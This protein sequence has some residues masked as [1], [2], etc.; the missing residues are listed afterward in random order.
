MIKHQRRARSVLYLVCLG[1]WLAGCTALGPSPG[2][3]AEPAGAVAGAADEAPFWYRLGNH[4]VQ[5]G[6]WSGAVA[7]YRQT[8]VADP[9]HY[10]AR[11]NLGLV[12]ARLSAEALNEAAVADPKAPDPTPLLKTLYRPW[13]K[14]TGARW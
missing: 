13:L 3:V 14:D 2:P 12:Y 7:A 9:G 5:R 11:H 8:L 6:D 4:R 10:R 1:G